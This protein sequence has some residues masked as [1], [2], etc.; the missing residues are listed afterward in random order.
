MP[1]LVGTRRYS[2]VLVG[3][4]LQLITLIKVAAGGPC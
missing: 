4:I 2:S 3:K 1:V